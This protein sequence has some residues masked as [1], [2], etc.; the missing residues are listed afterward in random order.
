MSAGL[1]VW[2]ENGSVRADWTTRIGKKLGSV[3]TGK[4]SGSV[5]VPAFAN[6]GIPAILMVHPLEA[7]T[8]STAPS[9]HISGNNVIWT[10]QNSGSNANGSVEIIYGII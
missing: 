8:I 5:N 2:N 7:A 1:K 6:G 4:T 9:V 10:Y 3:V